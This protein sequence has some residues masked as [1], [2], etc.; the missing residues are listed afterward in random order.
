ML[1]PNPRV[2]FAKRLDTG[3]PVPG[4]HLVFDGSHSIDLDTVPL[5]GGYLTKTL[6]LSPDPFLRERM[7]D[8]SIESYSTH[9]VVGAP[10]VGFVL[11]VVLRS[12]KEGVSPG[13]HLYGFSHWEVY[14][15]QPY[16]EGRVDFKA[17]HYPEWTSDTEDLDFIPM[18]DP[19]GAYPWSR[20]F[21]VLGG[22]GMTAFCGLEAYGDCKEGETIYISSGASGVGSVLIQLAKKKGLRVI[23]SAGSDAKVE[24]MQSLGAD[25]TFNYKKTPV[26]AAL[27]EH[28]PLDIYWDNVG[29]ETVEAALEYSR[30]RARFIMCGSISEYNVA[31]KDCYGVKNTSLIFKKQLRI[32]GLITPEHLATLGPRFLAEM[33]ALVAQGS[34][35]GRETFT[36]GLENAAEA[37]VKMLQEGGAEELGKPVVIVSKE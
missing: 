18:P 22:P 36:E 34:L 14:T 2:V 1:T 28:G 32:Y 3:L 7:R 37:F 20:Y 27:K 16:I 5:N 4:E 12:E 11:V 6:M 23:A 13:D 31:P 24:Y 33:P 26:A 19:K 17:G 10:M 15:V 25:I 35:T 9:A 21:S 29:G 8:L 30:L